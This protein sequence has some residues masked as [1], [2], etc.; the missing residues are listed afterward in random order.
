MMIRDASIKKLGAYRGVV[1]FGTFVA[2]FMFSVLGS[3]CW[4][5]WLTPYG[6]WL[7][8]FLCCNLR[9][10]EWC[11]RWFR[12]FSRLRLWCAILFRAQ[13]CWLVD[14]RFW[15]WS[16]VLWLCFFAAITTN[17]RLDF[18]LVLSRHGGIIDGRHDLF[19]VDFS[20]RG[21]GGRGCFYGYLISMMW[22][23][24]GQNV[25]RLLMMGKLKFPLA[26]AAL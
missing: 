18:V 9:I 1:A 19:L 21:D 6:D 10:C 4:R 12:S 8:H 5:F 25:H 24:V 17:S 13:R 3:R 11:W 20:D 22:W 23:N 26:G 16:G 15:I 2:V 7:W 14:D